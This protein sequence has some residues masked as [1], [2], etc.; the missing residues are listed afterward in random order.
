MPWRSKRFS[1]GCESPN[2]GSS[3]RKGQPFK[4]NFSRTVTSV[5]QQHWFGLKALTR[6]EAESLSSQNDFTIVDLVLFEHTCSKTMKQ[7]CLIAFPSQTFRK[8]SSSES[9]G[10]GTVNASQP[11]LQ[12]SSLLF[13]ST[14]MLPIPCSEVTAGV[15][16]G[17]QQ[18]SPTRS[19]KCSQNGWRSFCFSK[20][21]LSSFVKQGHGTSWV[22]L[23][24]RVT[25]YRWEQCNNRC[26]R[27][28]NMP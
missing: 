24:R 7:H 25:S 19:E 27:H 18:S 17:L 4:V 5:H 23:D 9:A 11:H 10:R 8:S 20:H 1:R 6:R 15:S 2:H 16:I 3:S 12:L 21:K 26:S 28:G 14:V 13:V 22:F